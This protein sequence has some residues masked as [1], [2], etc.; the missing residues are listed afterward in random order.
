MHRI[1]LIYHD[2]LFMN[3]SEHKP[4]DGTKTAF[5]ELAKALI[6]FS[7]KVHVLTETQNEYREGNFIW[8]NIDSF[9]PDPYYDLIIFNV[10]PYL[11]ERFR[12]VKAK[13][14]IL[15]VHN[16][17]KYL[18]FWKRYKYILRYF[19]TIVFSGKYHRSTF[20]FFLP[21]G[22]QKIISLGLSKELFNTDIPSVE[23][24]SR[25][26]FFTSN[27]LRSLRWLVDLWANYIFPAVPDAELHIFSGWQTYGGWGEKVKEKMETE[28]F[29]AS[30]FR[31][32]NVIVRGVL[33]KNELF[34]EMA[35]GRA[36]FY[37]GDRTETFCLAVAEAQALGLPAVVCDFGS[38]KER[39][40]NGITG[41]VVQNENDFVLK[42]IEILINDKV[43][44]NM[45]KNAIKESKQY[46]WDQAANKFLT[47]VS[48]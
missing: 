7:S 2:K 38:M 10:S 18:F 11:L 22:P 28:I 37:K 9:H 16:E 5:I 25:K 31:H 15:W 26:V 13:K 46:Q 42:A 39:V 40:L 32:R 20:P 29:Y 6:K 12:G 19:P 21:S 33:P 47:L 35:N 27:P 17:A 8:S 36:F 45:H 4:L 34:K 3:D 44:Q 43:W 48:N 14:K 1:L 30:G 41:Y 24:R 23:G